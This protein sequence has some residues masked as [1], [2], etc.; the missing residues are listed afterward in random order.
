MNV[1]C[2]EWKA[3]GERLTCCLLESDEGA[4]A[5]R[6]R[7]RRKALLASLVLQAA[8]LAALALLPLLAS[9]ARPSV[10]RVTPLPPYYGSSR[11]IRNVSPPGSNSRQP[12]I[13]EPLTYPTVYDHAPSLRGVRKPDLDAGRGDTTGTGEEFGLG[14]PHGLLP[15][16]RD[17]ALDGLLPQLPT[18]GA[19]P[20]KNRRP[21]VSEGVQEALLLL[22]VQPV[23]PLFALQTHLEG[24]VRLQAI[25]G[26]DGAVKS[27]E[28]I[29]GH[30]LLAQA[31]LAA[32]R[33]WRYR[34]THLNGEPVEVETYVTVIF[35]LQR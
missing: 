6:R 2:E 24:T 29:S 13:Y 7:I 34:P 22:R 20:S 11:A 32:V 12:K 26:R 10:L 9:S 31:A 4:T 23:Y 35:Q 27:L 25:I 19:L 1:R 3:S 17:A 15:A 28:L 16:S 18:L 33:E 5:Y 21:R 30:P 8:L 14:D